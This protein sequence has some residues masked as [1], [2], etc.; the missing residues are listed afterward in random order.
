MKIRQAERNDIK[1]WMELVEKLKH[2]FPGLESKEAILEH[3][4][5]VLDFM[6]KGLAL[7]AEEDGKIIGTLMFLKDEGQLCFLAVAP[8]YR[9]NHAAEMMVKEA[10]GQMPENI[11]VAVTT[12]REG[13]S[14]GRAARAFY[15]ALGFE[16]GELKEEFGSPVQEFILKR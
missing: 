11:D 16:E 4:N 9:R 13:S 5:T 14:E 6:D 10:L 12:Y 1:G 7:C 8:E 2:I 3:R 15:K